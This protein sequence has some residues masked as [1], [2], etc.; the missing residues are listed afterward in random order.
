MDKQTLTLIKRFLFK[1]F[2]VGLFFAILMFFATLYFWGPWS[3]L[4]ASKF[5]L[6][7]SELGE[8]VVK[9]FLMIRFYLVFVFLVPAIGLHWTLKE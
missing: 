5:Y 7:S 4:I 9:N 2:F 8:L 6:N 3:S 1:T